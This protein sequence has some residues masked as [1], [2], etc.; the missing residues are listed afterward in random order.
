VV[1]GLFVWR[2][3]INKDYFPDKKNKYSYINQIGTFPLG[4]KMR[5][6]F[7]V[8]V[9]CIASWRGRMPRGFSVFSHRRRAL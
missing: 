9:A 7:C 1:L 2:V 4:R 6:V 8:V 3:L 5:P